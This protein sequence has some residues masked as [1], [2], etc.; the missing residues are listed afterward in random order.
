MSSKFRA[1]RRRDRVLRKQSRG[2]VVII[3]LVSM[4][5]MFT[6]LV[7]FLLVITSSVVTMRNP[8][9][10]TLPNSVSMAPPNQDAPVLIVTRTQILLQGRPVMS[11]AAAE[12]TPGDILD[13]LRQQLLAVSIKK[14]AD[15]T[16]GETSRGKVNI[17]ADKSTPYSLLKKVMA[18]CG[19]IRFTD[20][21]LSVNHVPSHQT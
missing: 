7:F 13:P 21:S 20:I 3:N 1:N 16:S 18:T 2:G 14:V 17:M 5:D 12:N 11:V 19:D 15:S 4:I 6:A 9:S 10:L 8:N